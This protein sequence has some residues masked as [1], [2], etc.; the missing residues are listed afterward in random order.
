LGYSSYRQTIQTGRIYGQAGL[1]D[2]QSIQADRQDTDMQ[3]IQADR[4]YRKV[5]HANRQDIQTGKTCRQARHTDRE[6]IQ[7]DRQGMRTC[8]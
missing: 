2:N 5:G 6:G 7:T 1:T 8:R 4:T 3:G